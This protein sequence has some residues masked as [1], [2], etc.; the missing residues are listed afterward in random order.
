MSSVCHQGRADSTEALLCVCQVGVKAC[1]CIGAT[2][3]VLAHLAHP[4]H[5]FW[6]CGPHLISEVTL[7][8]GSFLSLLL[9]FVCRPHLPVCSHTIYSSGRVLSALERNG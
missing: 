4:L 7:L 3:G 9:L 8:A 6:W 1:D 5:V 2:A